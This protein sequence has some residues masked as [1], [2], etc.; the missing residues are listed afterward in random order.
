MREQCKG[1]AAYVQFLRDI[2]TTAKEK[3][4][5]VGFACPTALEI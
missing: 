4:A 3:E 2:H 5:A 1:V